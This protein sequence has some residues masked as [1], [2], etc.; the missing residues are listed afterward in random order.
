MKHSI[1]S[2]TL[3]FFLIVCSS[4]GYSNPVT[5]ENPEISFRQLMNGKMDSLVYKTVA[6]KPLHLY[7]AWPGKQNNVKG[8]TAVVIIHGGGWTAGG[9]DAF[10]LHA[11]YFASRGAVAFSVEY[12]LV[13]AYGPTIENSVADCQSAIRYIRSHAQE[14]GI[15]PNKI[16]VM[17]DSAGGHLSAC[18]GTVQGFDDPNDNL[19]VS[20]APNMAILC[21]PLSDFT[22]SSFIKIVVGGEALKSR[23][24]PDTASLPKETLLLARRLSPLYN[25]RKNQIR[26]LIMHGTDDTVISP[27]QSQAL[28]NSMKKAGNSC[29]L[30]LLPGARH[31]FV[32]TYYRASEKAVVDVI[33][34]IDDYMCRN[35][36]LQGKSN[37]V[38]S[39]A[40]L[41]KPLK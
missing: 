32:C 6:G 11:L 22:S 36:F 39:V 16:V 29:E 7:V 18:M 38:P 15:D 19:K 25:V 31:A 10:F 34:Q 27:L 3:F 12:R 4:C 14:W 1:I 8:R 24:N 35:G 23:I 5:I 37:L 21:N 9:A 30:I 40:E 26:T 41:W 17:G 13:K 28:Y 33:R 2:I 20:A